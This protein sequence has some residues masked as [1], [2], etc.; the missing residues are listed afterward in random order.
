M[1]ADPTALREIVLNLLSNAA[2]YSAREAPINI[3]L[4]H[5]HIFE[6]SFRPTR[7]APGWDAGC[8]SRGGL[9]RAHGG[10]TTVRPARHEGSE[11]VLELPAA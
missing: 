1:D 11:F 7:A 3:E 10:D 8:S 6:K 5:L 9:A 4:D 2:K